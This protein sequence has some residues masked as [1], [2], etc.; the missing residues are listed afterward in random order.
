MLCFVIFLSTS[1]PPLNNGDKGQGRGRTVACA[2]STIS[3][4]KDKDGGWFVRGEGQQ[5][6]G[7]GRGDHD[8]VLCCDFFSSPSSPPVNNGDK[9]GGQGRRLD[10]T[11]STQSRCIDG[12]GGCFG[13]RKG[14]QWK[15][16]GR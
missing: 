16:G 7:G 12:D 4:C 6:K 1:S 14:Q 11:T 2:A 8:D 3:G 9:K 5:W 15:G 10:C 13:V